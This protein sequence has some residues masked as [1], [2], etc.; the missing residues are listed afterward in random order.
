MYVYRPDGNL[1][2]NEVIVKIGGK[3]SNQVGYDFHKCLT[4]KGDYF[5]N[6]TDSLKS[7][8]IYSGFNDAKCS[9]TKTSSYTLLYFSRLANTF[10]EFDNVIGRKT[11]FCFIVGSNENCYDIEGQLLFPQMNI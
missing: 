11:N 10:D 2:G 1:T 3:V 4:N 7:D 5:G 9:V 6:S 8:L